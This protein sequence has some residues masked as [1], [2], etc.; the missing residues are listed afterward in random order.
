MKKNRKKRLRRIADRREQRKN[1]RSQFELT[2]TISMTQSGFGFVKPDM[3]DP[4]SE[5]IRDIFIPAKFVNGAID[6]DR[7]QVEV[8]PTMKYFV[9]IRA[10]EKGKDDESMEI[11]SY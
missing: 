7:V 6:G 9:E 4:E 11:S 2:G 3:D 5:D 10:I 8:S 1:S